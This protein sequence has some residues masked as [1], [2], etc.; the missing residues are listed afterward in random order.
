MVLLYPVESEKIFILD[1]WS[2]F[3]V[4]QY[5]HLLDQE[6]YYKMNIANL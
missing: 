5:Y 1:I 6:F 3:V 2:F 4:I